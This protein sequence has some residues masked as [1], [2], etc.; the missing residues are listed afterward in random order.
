MTPPS[1]PRTGPLGAASLAIAI[2]VTLAACALPRADAPAS[3]SAATPYA[4]QQTRDIKALSADEQ[5][6]LLAGRGMGLARAAELN[7]YP[8]PLHVLELGTQLELSAEQRARTEALFGSMQR[9]AA[10]LG[11]RIVDEERALDGLFV[12]KQASA[13][14]LAEALDRIGALQAALR[15][16]HL[17]AHLEQARILTPAQTARYVELRGYGTGTSGSAHGAHRHRH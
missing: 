9:E 2:A 3:P 15:R 6:D 11:A 7:G 17:D 8:G 5:A 4:G 10:R 13:T 12:S 1:H 14:T 16:T